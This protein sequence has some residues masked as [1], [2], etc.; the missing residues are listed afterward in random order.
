MSD[1]TV[2]ADFEEICRI[3]AGLLR[4]VGHDGG[5][6]YGKEQ[7]EQ[8]IPEFKDAWQRMTNPRYVHVI[9]SKIGTAM[10]SDWN[11]LFEE[12]YRQANNRAR[13]LSDSFVTPPPVRT[14]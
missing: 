12:A 5:F 4:R 10:N 6:D 7:W 14:R 1:E 13:G 9:K 2:E 3:W 11:R 8:D